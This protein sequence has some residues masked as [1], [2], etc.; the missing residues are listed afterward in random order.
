[1]KT[2]E[3]MADEFAEREYIT[4]QYEKERISFGYYHGATNQHKIDVKR[5]CEAYCNLECGADH[6]PECS[7]SELFLFKQML[8]K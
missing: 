4:N 5:A 8:E 1:M 2:I 3:E 6:N 7:C